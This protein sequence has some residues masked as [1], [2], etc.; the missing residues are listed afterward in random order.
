MFKAV[1]DKYILILEII[2]MII[3]YLKDRKVN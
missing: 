3:Q 2:Q 1:K